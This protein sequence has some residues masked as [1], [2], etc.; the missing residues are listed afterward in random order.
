MKIN[1]AIRLIPPEEVG[2][3]VRY[4][5]K[6]RGRWVALPGLQSA[7]VFRDEDEARKTAVHT[8]AYRQLRQVGYECSVI[9]IRV[10]ET[11]GV[12]HL[13]EVPPLEQLARALKDAGAE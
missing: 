13:F 12:S 2:D 7:Y 3:E 10:V 1:C 11:N 5:L 4:L 8:S 9:Q 6:V